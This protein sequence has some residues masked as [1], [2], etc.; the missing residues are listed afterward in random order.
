M[1][2]YVLRSDNLVKIGFSDN[3]RSRVRA[4][5]SSVPVPVEFVGHMPGGKEVEEH[6][7][8]I[9][10]ASRFS[11]EWFV[12]SE[13]MR[14]VFETLLTPRL[15]DPERPKQIKRSVEK[16]STQQVSLNVRDAAAHKWPTK[17]K[18]EIV[19]ALASDLGWS[20]TR[21]RDFYYADPRIAL[22]AYEMAEVDKW[23]AAVRSALGIRH[24]A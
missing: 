22:R 2:I 5:I 16:T 8:S 7:H 19:D 12:E 21:T 15:P 3:L 6:L 18:S 10:A 13:E 17:S 4:I 20:R 24:R 1:S 11:G 14:A 23:L 9:F